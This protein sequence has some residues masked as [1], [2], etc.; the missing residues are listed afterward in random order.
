MAVLTVLAVARR[1]VGRPQRVLCCMFAG[2]LAAVP[3]ARAETTYR[4]DVVKAAFLFRFTGYVE[5]PQSATGSGQFTIATLG[6][7]G[8]AAELTRLIERYSIK[9]RPARVRTIESAA[10]A[11]DAQ[12]LYVGAD[13]QGSLRGVTQALGT[14]PVLVVTDHPNGLDEGSA[15]NFLIV[16]RRVRFEVSLSAATRAG[17]HLSSQLLSVAARVRGAQTL[18]PFESCQAG[19]DAEPADVGCALRVAMR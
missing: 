1:L 17:L 16:D 10:Q 9:N 4:D 19:D 15:V 18:R 5:W 8:V 14:R 6:S 12:M 2:L 13:F 3:G 7:P 11:S